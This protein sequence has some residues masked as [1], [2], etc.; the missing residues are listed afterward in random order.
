MRIIRPTDDEHDIEPG[1]A[2]FLAGT[3]DNGKAEPWAHLIA[4]EFKDQAINFFDPR[5]AIWDGSMEQR[6]RNPVF[7]HQVEWETAHLEG[8]DIPFFN[9]VGG[10]L[11]PVTIG[12]INYVVAS[13]A[14]ATVFRPMP[15]VVCPDDF[16]RKGNIELLCEAHDIIVHN[17][18]ASG[19]EALKVAISELQSHGS[20]DH[21]IDRVK[22][23][24]RIVHGL[25]TLLLTPETWNDPITIGE[26][27]RIS[28]K[29]LLRQ[30]N[31]GRKAV[32]D[33]RREINLY[34][35]RTR[36]H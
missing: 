22:L 20:P 27:D 12:E 21:T 3:I 11:S 34:L 13:R 28:D 26:V 5:R 10:S 9:F 1:L 18:V 30:K 14:N 2:V 19:I 35:G 32:A 6:A 29:E 8:C 15:I 17:D 36:Q 7:R 4:D 33:L 24:P 25:K 31:M 23:K 16:W